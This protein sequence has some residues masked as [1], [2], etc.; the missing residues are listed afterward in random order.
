VAEVG[1]EIVAALAIETGSVIANPFRNTAQLVA[2]LRLR[3]DQLSVTIPQ[4]RTG[5]RRLRLWRAAPEA[6]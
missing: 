4:A 3:A 6:Q 2:L 5:L 1:G